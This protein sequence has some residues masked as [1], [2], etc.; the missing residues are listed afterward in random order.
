MSETSEDFRYQASETIRMLAL[1][2]PETSEG[3][4]CV[5]RAF[6]AGNKNFAFL[7]EKDELCGLRLKLASS[8][9]ELEERAKL[10]PDRYQVGKGGWTMVRFAPD[11]PPR[12]DDLKTWLLESFVLLAP[13]R[14]SAKLDS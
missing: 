1:Q 7:G 5:N 13:K 10:Q 12:T 14:V 2:L 3:S 9:P 6:K 8:I 4:S 11:D